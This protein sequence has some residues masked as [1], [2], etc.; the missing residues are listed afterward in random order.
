MVGWVLR[1]RERERARER[2][3]AHMLELVEAQR[4]RKI[5]NLKQTPRLQS[6]EP[7][8]GLDLMTLRS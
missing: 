2:E 1:E 4:E 3:H 6:L 7:D 8:M 5:E